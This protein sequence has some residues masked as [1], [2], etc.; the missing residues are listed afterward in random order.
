VGANWRAHI[1]VA[2]SRFGLG[3]AFAAA[4]LAI[5]ACSKRAPEDSAQDG[6]GAATSLGRTGIVNLA[7]GNIAWI[8]PAPMMQFAFE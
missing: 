4:A 7:T 6:G 5:S 2:C 3:V 1:D 8:D